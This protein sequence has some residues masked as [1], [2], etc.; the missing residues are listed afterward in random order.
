M[1]DRVRQ[2][3]KTEELAV[4]LS[5]Y[6]LGAIESV[7]RFERGS[8]MSPKVGIVSQRGKFL[9]KKR[10]AGRKSARRVAFAHLVQEHLAERGFP[11]PKLILTRDGETSVTRLGTETYE[12]FDFVSGQAYSGSDEQ[13]RDA[14]ATLARLHVAVG[15]LAI[16]SDAPTGSY[17]DT[18]GVRTALSAVP[19]SISSHDS[20]VGFEMDLRSLVQVLFED[21]DRAAAAADNAGMASFP[22]QVVHADWH[23]GNMLF[24]HQTIAAVID[25]DSCSV[26]PRV[27]DVAN[28]ALHFSLTTETNLDAWPQRVDENRLNTFLAGYEAVSA[29]SNQERQAAPHLMIEALIAESVLPVAR[30][31]VFGK[32]A[33]F[34]FLKM[35]ARKTNWLRENADRLFATQG[36]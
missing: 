7:T 12:L 22:P 16:P 36:E 10:A 9:L 28:G 19:H 2:R 32:W 29:L 33:G 26:A 25:Y 27:V 11:L 30:T 31:G 3:F 18:V 8:S 1:Q 24:R 17:H 13:T 20:V 34:G 5:H 23:P 35:V 14:G 6:D 15:D 21:Y 4:V